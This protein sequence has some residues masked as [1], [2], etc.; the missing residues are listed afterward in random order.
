MH[1]SEI[2]GFVRNGFLRPVVKSIIHQVLNTT[3]VRTDNGESPKV[4]TIYLHIP[5]NSNEELLLPSLACTKFS[6]I[7]SKLVPLNLRLKMMLIKLIY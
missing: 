4:L 2:L 6:L 7:V 5:Y 3:D 1:F